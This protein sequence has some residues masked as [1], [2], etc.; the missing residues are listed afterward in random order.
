MNEQA[1]RVLTGVILFTGAGVSIYFRHRADRA[2]GGRVPRSADGRAMEAVIRLFGLALWLTPLVYLA[3][4]AW[5]A[6]AKMGLPEWARWTGVAAGLA[7]AA[8]I[9][10]LF[11][12]IG[13]GITPTSVTRE[14]HE[15][16]TRGPYRWI[17]HPL[18]TFGTAWFVSLGVSSDTWLIAGLGILA[19]IVMA[20][21]TPREEAQ[22]VATFGDEYRRYM[23]RTGRFLP[24]VSRPAR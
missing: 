7:C 1:F 16:S 14:R 10:W 18:Y 5:L 17:R 15:L 9:Y 6:W 4:P 3:N 8:G 20:V 11:R 12:S 23:A 13:T 2:A 24:R 22:L 21:R 19:F